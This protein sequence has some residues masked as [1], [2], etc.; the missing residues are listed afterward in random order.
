MWLSGSSRLA[1]RL[2]LTPASGKILSTPEVEL[3]VVV[4]S[5]T[6][7]REDGE[8][9]YLKL[10]GALSRATWLAPYFARIRWKK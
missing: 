5:S 2:L 4:H 8:T 6:D 10:A 7:T 9:S 1:L 3:S